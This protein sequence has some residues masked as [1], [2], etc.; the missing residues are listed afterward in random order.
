MAAS[1]AL[2]R[3]DRR[4]QVAG[5]RAVSTKSG[6]DGSALEALEGLDFNDFDHSFG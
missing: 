1:S 5:Q 3:L 4:L 2:F 6:E